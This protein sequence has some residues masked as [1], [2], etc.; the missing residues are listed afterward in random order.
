MQA[1]RLQG[2]RKVQRRH[3]H[4]WVLFEGLKQRLAEPIGERLRDLPGLEG[5][6]PRV[7]DGVLQGPGRP[8][9]RETRQTLQNHPALREPF[10]SA[11]V[12]PRAESGGPEIQPLPETQEQ[13]TQ[14]AG[15]APPGK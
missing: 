4:W 13:E 7:E 5:A 6:F 3:G 12:Q 1:P 8:L 11:D 2:L 15:Q 9:E 10:D 14:Q